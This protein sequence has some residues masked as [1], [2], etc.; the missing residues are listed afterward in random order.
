MPSKESNATISLSTNV[1]TA[2]VAFMHF[3]FRNIEKLILLTLWSRVLPE[4]ITVPRLLK[5]FP[6]FYG[7][8][9]FIT[10]FTRAHHLSLSRATRAIPIIKR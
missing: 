6:A 9:T 7:T 1:M 2:D 5:I 8:R 4:K 10:A 3:A